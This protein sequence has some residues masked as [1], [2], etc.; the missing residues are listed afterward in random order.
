MRFRVDKNS[1]C[2]RYEPKKK[3]KDKDIPLNAVDAA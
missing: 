3:K 2:F 1:R